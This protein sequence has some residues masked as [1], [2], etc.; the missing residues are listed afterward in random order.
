MR[1]LALVGLLLHLIPVLAH[2]DV[3]SE[4]TRATAALTAGIRAHDTRAIAK[5]FGSK[6]TNGGVWFAD[7]ACATEFAE[8]SDV[9]GKRVR[10]FVRCLAKHR[11]QLSTRVS[12]RREGAVLTVEPGIE[13]ELSFRDSQVRWIGH[14]LHS[15][16]GPIIP[17]LTAQAFEALRT[18][19]TTN[20][21]RA[22]PAKALELAPG[23]WT[24]AWIKI[25]LDERGAK[26]AVTYHGVS[27]SAVGDAFLRAIDDWTFRPF[28]LRGTAIAACSLSHLTYPTDK[29]PAIETLPTTSM[30]GSNVQLYETDG[31]DTLEIY[32]GFGQVPPPAAPSPQ[33]IASNKLER[34]RISGTRDVEPD[35]VTRAQMIGAGRLS[36]LATI[37]LCVSTRGRVA[38]ATV[39]KSSGFPAYDQKILREAGRWT[40][41]PYVIA[42]KPVDVCTSVSFFV[43]PDPT[44]LN[45]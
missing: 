44:M 4:T 42:K 11:V 39:Q 13:I 45:P 38:S 6:F 37:K 26:A 28:E 41:R 32:G 12:S 27:S 31:L 22:L 36:V 14:P 16:T 34:L 24:S 10:V 25:C 33:S 1:A 40:Y 35:A 17:T 20:L 43:V 7:A 30:P 15:A 29:A 21:D 5:L 9:T 18:R 23:G 8:P 2:A 19:G 3:E